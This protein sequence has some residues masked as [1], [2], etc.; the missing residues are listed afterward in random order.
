LDFEW[1]AQDPVIDDSPRYSATKG[2][3]D[4]FDIVIKMDTFGIPI[5]VITD[6]LSYSQFTIEFWFYLENLN[7][8]DYPFVGIGAKPIY[9]GFSITYSK[10]SG[11]LFCNIDSVSNSNPPLTTPYTPTV[12]KWTHVAC[13]DSSAFSSSQLVI[14]DNIVVTKSYYGYIL[15]SN[16]S[17]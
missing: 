10:T 2:N 17:L 7:Q 14:D 8:N 15:S 6:F 16:L 1:Q 9:E 4:P 13:S 12:N 11:K 3:F 5:P